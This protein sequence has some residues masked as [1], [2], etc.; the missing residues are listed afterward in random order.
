M[1]IITIIIYM[2]RTKRIAGDIRLLGKSNNEE[3]SFAYN[4]DDISTLYCT[5][6]GPT[7][8]CYEGCI[9]YFI[10]NL[11]TDYL[12]SPPIFKFI[13]PINKRFHPNL[14][15]EGKVCLTILNTW[16]SANVT[17]W[18]TATTIESILTTI[19]SMLHDNP[20]TEEPGQNYK[21]THNNALNYS[22]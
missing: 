3:Y 7:G 5:I 15:A 4:P 19:R 10:I 2:I 11:P 20:I 21:L 13:T 14:Y 6:Y 8:S 17:G 9:L 1:L 12:I 16:R 22:C 18:T